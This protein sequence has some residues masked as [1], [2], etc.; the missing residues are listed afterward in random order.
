MLAL[1]VN[2]YVPLRILLINVLENRRAL[3]AVQF[4]RIG[5]RQAGIEGVLDGWRP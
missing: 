5:A 1:G 2:A 3:L 4:R